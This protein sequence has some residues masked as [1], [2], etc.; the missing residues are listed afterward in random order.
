M[1]TMAKDQRFNLM[2]SEED[3]DKLRALADAEGESAATIVRQLV[4]RAYAEKFPKRP[5]K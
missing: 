1:R 2:M 3:A 5:K 4:R